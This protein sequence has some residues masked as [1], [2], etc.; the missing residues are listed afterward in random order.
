MRILIVEDDSSVSYWL[1]SKLQA[2][3]HH[4][5]LVNNGQDALDAVS[6][7]AFDV[8][9]LDRM[10]PIVDGM[11][12]L[13]HLQH[14]RHPPILVLSAL[15]QP[16]DR[17]AGLRA[18]ADDYL[19]KPF[20]FSELLARIDV[21]GRRAGLAETHAQ[22]LNLEDLSMDVVSREVRR[23]GQLLDLTDK[24]FKLLQ[25]LMEHSGQV[26]TRSMLL[27]RVWGYEFDPQ[28]NLIDVH[29]S[30]LRAKLDKRFG[31]PLL[32]TIR[33]VGYALG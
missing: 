11:Q 30:K 23:N 25:V 31:L 10:L 26:V 15:D 28:T 3:G 6:R 5:T 19:G 21:L 1:T 32:R 33:S 2:C 12:V 29:M 9:V 27:Q 8:M 17:V 20:H 22:M 13:E 24:E 4:C 18:G 16:D 7:E 14:R